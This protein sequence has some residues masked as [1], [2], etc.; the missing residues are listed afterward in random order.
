MSTSYELGTVP[1]VPISLSPESAQHPTRFSSET[2]A[3]VSWV[4]VLSC[5]W[6]STNP[7]PVQRTSSSRPHPECN[8]SVGGLGCHSPF[9]PPLRGEMN[10]RCFFFSLLSHFTSPLGYFSHKSKASKYME[11]DQTTSM[12]HNL[13]NLQRALTDHQRL[14]PCQ[15]HQRLPWYQ[16]RPTGPGTKDCLDLELSGFCSCLPPAV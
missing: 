1:S 16:L 7:R 9:L 14:G 11:K 3:Y 8:A 15:G 6:K 2:Y 10:S 13:T 5:L 4:L 12:K